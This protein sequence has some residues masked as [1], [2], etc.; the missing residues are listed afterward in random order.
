MKKNYY[1]YHK[2]NGKKDRKRGIVKMLRMAFVYGNEKYD[3]SGYIKANYVEI[4]FFLLF[5]FMGLVKEEEIYIDIKEIEQRKLISDFTNSEFVKKHR[6]LAYKLTTISIVIS[7][8]IWLCNKS[9]YRDV[10]AELKSRK[11]EIKSLRDS[12]LILYQK[13][14]GN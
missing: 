9:D 11:L 12:I 5:D 4:L 14:Q 6:W 7:I 10:K 2:V 1:L 8:I 3:M 13:K